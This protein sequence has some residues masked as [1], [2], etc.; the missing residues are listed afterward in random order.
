MKADI[1]I[2]ILNYNRSKFLD[3]SIRSCAD[4]I[5]FNKKIELIF[6]DDGSTDGSLQLVKDFKIPNLKILFNKSNKG[7]GFSSKKAV[8]ISTG[9]YFMRVDSDDFLN[10]HAIEHM[11]KI[12]DHNDNYAFVNCD[13]VKVNENGIK[14]KILSTKNKKVLKNH[15]AGILFR[16]SCVDKVGGYNIKLREAEDFDLITRLMKKFDYFHLPLPFYRYYQHSNNI[17]K[18]GNRKIYLKKIN[19]NKL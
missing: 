11:S 4:Q 17:S 5:I 13:L 3:R 15:G 16:K 14:Q 19:K 6:C 1:S 18:S 9:K 8:K 12:L 2:I 7:I 10:S